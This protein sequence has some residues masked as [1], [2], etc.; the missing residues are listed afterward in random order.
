MKSTP[1][2]EEAE[3]FTYLAWQP[4]EE[5][6]LEYTVEAPYDVERGVRRWGLRYVAG[7]NGSKGLVECQFG[8]WR[9]NED[10]IKSFEALGGGDEV[11]I[12]WEPFEFM[13]KGEVNHEARYF[14]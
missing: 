13:E 6:A 3:L 1:K 7:K 4:S 14:V 2:L 11:E 12:T 9:S 10:V 8:D 5:R